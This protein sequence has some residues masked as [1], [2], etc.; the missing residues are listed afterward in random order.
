M[1]DIR[2][3][4]ADD[5]RVVRHALIDL[6]EAS[7]GM[8]V[9]AVAKDADEAMAMAASARPDVAIVDVRMPGGGPTATRGILG[10]SARTRVLALTASDSRDT[11]ME[12]L[13]AGAS[14]YLVK[15]DL[16]LEVIEGIR[17]VA[18]GLTPISAEVAGGV[19]ERVR[20]HMTAETLEGE[21]R[22]Q[23]VDKLSL[24]L[25]GD[26]LDMVY[27]PI[28]EL[29]SRSL[30]GVES[31]ARFA[32]EP[33]RPPNEWFDAAADVGMAT[34][35]EMTALTKGHRPPLP[36][37]RRGV[38]GCEPVA[39]GA[40]GTRGRGPGPG[41]LRQSTGGGVDRAQAGPRLPGTEQRIRTP[42]PVGGR[43]RDR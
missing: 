19:I 37:S 6:V 43:A 33:S 25:D 21:H 38:H 39:R 24:A 8:T 36:A 11:V 17:R 16:P 12:M 7:A 18:A 4:V 14:G 3:L 13:Q 40:D 20:A 26:C 32:L 9:V 10:G 31:L 30:V 28:F 22:Q 27:Q 23:L 35:L 41:R 2:V 42:A 1:A 29:E 34:R 5:E 15:G